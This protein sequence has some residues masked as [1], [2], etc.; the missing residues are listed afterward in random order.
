MR[1]HGITGRRRAWNREAGI[2]PGSTGNR[3]K[4]IPVKRVTVSHDITIIPGHCIMIIPG[5]C[6][7][8]IPGHCIMIIPG[9]CIIIIPGHCLFWFHTMRLLGVGIMYPVETALM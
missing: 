8:I 4:R 5:H 3:F 9:H 1:R 7:I 6:I 2:I